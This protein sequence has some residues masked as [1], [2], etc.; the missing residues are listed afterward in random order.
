MMTDG[1]PHGDVLDLLLIDAPPF[2]GGMAD[3]VV[4]RVRHRRRVQRFAALSIGST[5]ALGGTVAVL[6]VAGTPDHKAQLAQSPSPTSAAST[7]PAAT[8]ASLIEAAAIRDLADRVADGRRWSVLFV[9]DHRRIGITGAPEAAREGRLIARDEQEALRAALADYAPLEFVSNRSSA[10]TVG[11]LAVR[12]GGALVTLGELQRLGTDR[13]TLSLSVQLNGLNGRG[14]TYELA[15][16]ASGWE[17]TGTTG[18][19]WIS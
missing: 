14:V 7:R 18:P 15:R 17:V 5:L 8:S 19:M 3:A 12:D 16:H 6:A 10:Y 9:M 2:P 1:D 4:Q 11:T 13:A